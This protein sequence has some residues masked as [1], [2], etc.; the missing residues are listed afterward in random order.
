M[1]AMKGIDLKKWRPEVMVIEAD[2]NIDEKHL[3]E[4]ILFQGYNKLCRLKE[5]IFYTN[6]SFKFK[7]LKSSYNNIRLTHTAHPIDTNDS[8]LTFQSDINIDFFKKKSWSSLKNQIKNI[9]LQDFIK[10][11]R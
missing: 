8:D 10:N 3:D 11:T 9:N 4:I 6:K 2:S 1:E 5:N 7:P